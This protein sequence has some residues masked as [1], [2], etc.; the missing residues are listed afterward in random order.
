[1]TYR[2]RVGNTLGRGF[3]IWLKNFVPFT[4]LALLIG[5]PLAA[6]PFVVPLPP[7]WQRVL[8]MPLTLLGSTT[9]SGMVT[10]TVF[11]QLRNRSTT[12]GE[13]VSVG[14]ARLLPVLGTGIIVGICLFLGFIACVVPGFIM[15][16]ALFVAV[17]VCVVERPGVTGSL[18]RS[19]EL[20][21]N[22]RMTLFLVAFVSGL[23]VGICQAALGGLLGVLDLG[24]GAIEVAASLIG[25][26]MAAPNSVMQA[27]A[28]HDLRIGK[29]GV[30]VEELVAV[31]E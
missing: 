19:F 10:F 27:V 30:D 14:V 13:T 8:S 18:S 25:M 2:L 17:P 6:L 31:F 4:L 12:L 7:G 28:Y 26:I 20:T 23:F 1:V 29:E 22:S 16:A 11:N 24:E 3:S 15:Q 21:E 9:L 5:L